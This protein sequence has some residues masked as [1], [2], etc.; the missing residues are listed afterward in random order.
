MFR[1]RRK[2]MKN[3]SEVWMKPYAK[4]QKAEKKPRPRGWHRT[5]SQKTDGDFLE[6]KIRFK[7]KKA[8]QKLQGFFVPVNDYSWEI[9]PVGQA[10][11]QLPQSKHSSALIS[12]L[13]SPSLIAPTD[14]RQRS[15][16]KKC[17]H[18]KLH[19]PLVLPPYRS[20]YVCSST[21]LL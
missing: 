17:N 9:A 13:P 12:N 10:A 4:K 11:A 15:F 7:Y 16:H 1:L 18:Q 3:A 14:I 6:R 5:Q 8:L 20:L 19:M 2:R 21:T